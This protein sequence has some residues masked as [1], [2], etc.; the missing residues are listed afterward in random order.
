[1]LEGGPAA[2]LVQLARLGCD[3]GGDAR[4]A[5]ALRSVAEL[6]DHQQRYARSRS[7]DGRR[8]AGFHLVLA[9]AAVAAAPDAPLPAAAPD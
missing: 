1:M 2:D 3:V 5:P 8:A 9:A 6:L 4:E 7:L